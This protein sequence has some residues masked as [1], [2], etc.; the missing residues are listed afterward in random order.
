MK[1]KNKVLIIVASVIAGIVLVLGISNYNS[2]VEAEETVETA[3]SNIDSMLQRRADLIPQLVDTVKSF[4]NHELSV[5][6]S[7][8]EARAAMVGAQTTEEKLEASEQLST[9]VSELRIFLVENY[10][11]IQSS[12]SYTTLMDEIAGSENRIAV[13]RN[14]YN[15]AVSDYNKKIRSFPGNIY[16][17]IFG[18]EKAEYYEAS[19]GVET[20]PDV[21]ELF[22]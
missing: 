21:G 10:P 2:I 12:D 14:D 19:E 3:N 11:E 22:G 15:E 17:S 20:A 9:A 5:V 8:T 6:D 16:A 18:F 1:T 7:V 13:A 4:T